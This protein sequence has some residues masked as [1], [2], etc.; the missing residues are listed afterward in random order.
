MKR[1]T[2]SR[3]AAVV[4]AVLALAASITV[5]AASRAHGSGAPTGLS[6]SVHERQRICEEIWRKIGLWYSYFDEK[7][8]DWE[9]VRQPYL[10]RVAAAGS[11]REFFACMTSPGVRVV[12]A[13]GKP[14]IAQVAPGSDAEAKGVLPGQVIVAV[15]GD[16]ARGGFSHR[17]RRFP[18]SR[19]AWSLWGGRGLRRA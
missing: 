7:G 2:L 14:V 15:D 10:D 11:D 12:E 8:I 4:G 13:E 17:L 5:F 19:C 3:A 9:S 16:A 18:A 6:Y 1:V